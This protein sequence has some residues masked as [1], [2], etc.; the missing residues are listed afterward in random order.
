[1]T[2]DKNFD[3]IHVYFSFMIGK[4]AQIRSFGFVIIHKVSPQ[5]SWTRDEARRRAMFS[6]WDH[7]TSF[8]SLRPHRRRVHSRSHQQLLHHP[9]MERRLRLGSPRCISEPLRMCRAANLPRF[10]LECLH[11]SE[12]RSS[13]WARKNRR[14]WVIQ[15]TWWCLL[16]R[17]E[18]SVVEEF[19]CFPDSMGCPDAA[20]VG[21]R[22]KRCC[23]RR[24]VISGWDSMRERSGR[25]R[26]RKDA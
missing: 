1:M 3:R 23:R 4:V 2:D 11:H 22:G 7:L 5:M 9:K 15:R 10:V 18:F 20:D 19:E 8:H 16:R 13:C 6:H 21:I 12:L 25:I 14:R 24:Y 17:I 26:I